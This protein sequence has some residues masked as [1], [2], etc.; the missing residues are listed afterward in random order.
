MYQACNNFLGTV[1]RTLQTVPHH[2]PGTY[3]N[4]ETCQDDFIEKEMGFTEDKSGPSAE[5][6]MAQPGLEP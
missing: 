3:C 6:Q 2:V 1:S 4:I 5:W